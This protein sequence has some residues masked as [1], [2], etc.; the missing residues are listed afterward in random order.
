[1]AFE[2]IQNITTGY[3]LFLFTKSFIRLKSLS[4]YIKIKIATN[5]ERLW[6][7]QPGALRVKD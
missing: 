6:V 1:M 3:L 5:D 7:F 4:S 2:S